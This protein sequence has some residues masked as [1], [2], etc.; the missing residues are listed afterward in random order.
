M[1][2]GLN[3]SPPQ[4]LSFEGNVSNNWHVWK[5]ELTLY[6]DAT[7]SSTKSDK[8]KASIFLT[9]I[10]KKGREIYNTFTFDSDGDN[11]K[12]DKIIEKF[13]GYCAPRKNLTFLRYTFL[14]YWQQDGESFD[15]FTTTLRK[16]SQDCEFGDL[17]DSLI[18]DM[19]TIG[20]N[21]KALQ[22]RMLR[23]PDINLDRC[24]KLGQAAEITRKHAKII[25]AH[26]EEKSTAA[27]GQNRA[28]QETPLS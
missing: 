11:M 6:L 14:T 19:I 22:E 23:E 18:N 7:E 16:L 27:N 21:D 1:E 3:F 2:L 12:L 17:K 10:G 25:Q 13:E 9:C 24:I 26:S 20:T 28:S 8:V 4:P 15:E 5:Q